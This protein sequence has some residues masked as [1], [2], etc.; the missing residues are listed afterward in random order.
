M[1]R[2]IL[3][4]VVAA[5]A[6]AMAAPMAQ[7][8][9]QVNVEFTDIGVTE[10]G[11]T[12]DNIVNVTEPALNQTRISDPAGVSLAVQNSAEVTCAQE[13]SNQV[14]CTRTEPVNLSVYTNWGDDRVTIGPHGADETVGVALHYGNDWVDARNGSTE[15]IS[16]GPGTD[17]AI[18]DAFD[19]VF[20]AGAQDNGCNDGAVVAAAPVAVDPAVAV[21]ALRLRSQHP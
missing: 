1:R 3:G 6:V 10:S 7:A 19:T 5:C 17:T 2:T 8:A 21:E 15:T 11:E 9:T 18:T 20:L 14:T 16:C 13:G 4:V 12:A